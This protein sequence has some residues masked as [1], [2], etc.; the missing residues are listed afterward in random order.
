MEIHIAK[1]DL[2]C[3]RLYTNKNSKVGPV[4]PINIGLQQACIGYF[5]ICIEKSD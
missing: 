2:N 1:I 3:K 5:Y 4:G